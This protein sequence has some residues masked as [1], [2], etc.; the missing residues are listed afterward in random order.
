MASRLPPPVDVIVAAEES[1]GE[2]IRREEEEVFTENHFSVSLERKVSEAPEC[3]ILILGK[4]FR[5]VSK[6]T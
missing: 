4:D 3:S 6:V 2:G 5:I 1:E